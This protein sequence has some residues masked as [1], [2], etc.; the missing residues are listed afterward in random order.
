MGDL[1]MDGFGWRKGKVTSLSY[2]AHITLWCS[3]SRAAPVGCRHG[4][5]RT[6][7][8]P[9]STSWASTS[10]FLHLKLPNLLVSLVPAR[11]ESRFTVEHLD[12]SLLNCKEANRTPY[13][14]AR[15]TG[16]MRPLRRS[17]CLQLLLASPTLL[18]LVSRGSVMLLVSTLLRG[19][20]A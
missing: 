3:P 20:L 8:Q 17:P 13:A 18:L 19:S 15:T 6:S 7:A 9:R 2:D 1:C 16:K 12:I 5:R 14:A 11:P 4:C 10:K